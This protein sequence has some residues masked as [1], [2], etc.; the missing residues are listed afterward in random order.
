MTKR[1]MQIAVLRNEFGSMQGMDPSGPVYARLC[2]ILDKADKVA[3][4]ALVA[5]DIKF[6]SKLARNRL[7]RSGL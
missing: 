1:S 3:L 4:A 5:A 6:V 7:M 2:E